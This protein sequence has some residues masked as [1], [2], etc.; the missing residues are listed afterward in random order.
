MYTIIC[1]LSYVHC[2]MYSSKG[3]GRSLCDNKS[4]LDLH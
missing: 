3:K 4:M 2:Q 1:T